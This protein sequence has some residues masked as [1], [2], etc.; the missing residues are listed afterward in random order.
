LEDN[1]ALMHPKP[2]VVTTFTGKDISSA[3]SIYQFTSPVNAKIQIV[4]RLTNAAGG[5]TYTIYLTHRW[6]NT[7]VT[8]EILPRTTTTVAAGVTAFEDVLDIMI[9]GRPSDT[10]V[11]GSI[12]IIADNPSVYEP[13]IV[14]VPVTEMEANRVTIIRGDKIDISFSNLGSLSGYTSID[15]TVKKKARDDDDDAILRVRK[16][17]SGIGDGLLRLN[18]AVATATDGS[19]TIVDQVVGNITVNVMAAESSELT[20]DDNLFYDVQKI[21]TPDEDVT[22]LRRGYC[23]V[24]EDITRATT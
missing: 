4:A 22:T 20:V 3:S 18:G 23:S 14:G 15:F 11:D 21:T 10:S 5:G 17:S 13:P 6:L 2:L 9:E 1:M 16:N 7:G 12:R 8:A 19:I 24:S